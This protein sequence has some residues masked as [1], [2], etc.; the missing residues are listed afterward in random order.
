[1]YS[2][3]TLQAGLAAL[4]WIVVG[5]GALIAVVSPRIDDILSER[6]ALG[7]VSIGAFGTAWRV[8][9]SG[10]VTD[11]GLWIASGLALYVCSLFW[12]H[13]KRLSGGSA[14]KGSAA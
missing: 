9:M 6:I 3:I 2:V 8:I 13:A 12:K 7:L 5:L 1:M 10:E 4:C 11:G 14:D